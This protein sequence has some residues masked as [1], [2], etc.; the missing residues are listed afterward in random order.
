M[1]IVRPDFLSVMCPGLLRKVGP[2]RKTELTGL[3]QEK[4]PRL[5]ER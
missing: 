1:Q 4:R 2:G 5:G 3:K